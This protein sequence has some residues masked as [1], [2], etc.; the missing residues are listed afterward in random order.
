MANATFLHGKECKGILHL[1]MSTGFT[2]KTPSLGI[3]PNGI[4]VGVL[5]LQARS[6][7][8]PTFYCEMC[9]QSVTNAEEI[10]VQCSICDKY[11]PVK[12]C[13]TS[14]QI[15]ILCEECRSMLSGEKEPNDKIKNISKYLSIKNGGIETKPL[16]SVFKKKILF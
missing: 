9:S 3:S 7:I 5:E 8:T 4:V 14:H 1:D 11:N 12:D 6:K 10:N 16:S 13:H 15:N 2:L